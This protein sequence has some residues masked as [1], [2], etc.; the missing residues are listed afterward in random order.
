MSK[1]TDEGVQ[2]CQPEV[3]NDV[4]LKSA[5][6]RTRRPSHITHTYRPWPKGQNHCPR[7]QHIRMHIQFYNMEQK[8]DPN[9][10][11]DSI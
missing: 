9:L 1:S 11:N 4:T 2:V 8:L 3:S 5:E 10:H 6:Y 7:V